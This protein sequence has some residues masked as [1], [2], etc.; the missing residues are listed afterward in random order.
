MTDNIFEIATRDAYRFDTGKGLLSVE[1][2]WDLPLSSEKG[3]SLNGIFASLG[4]AIEAA[5]KATGHSLVNPAAKID[6]SL[7][8]KSAI[9]KHIFEVRSAENKAK[10]DKVARAESRRI[11][12]DTIRAK[13]ADQIASTSLEDLEKQLAALKDDDA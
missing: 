2:L 13:K 12:E 5:G 10:L 6:A 9:V 8:V 4:D 1:E 11:I 3:T 7:G